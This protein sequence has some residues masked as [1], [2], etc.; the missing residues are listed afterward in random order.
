MCLYVKN[1]L[2]QNIW[3]LQNIEHSFWCT[4]LY[5]YSHYFLGFKRITLHQFFLKLTTSGDLVLKKDLPKQNEPLSKFKDDK[6][7]IFE[8]FNTSL[9]GN[10]GTGFIFERF[11]Y[12]AL[13]L[14]FHCGNI[15][16]KWQA[17]SESTQ[18]FASS[19]FMTSLVPL[20]KWF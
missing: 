12:H 8:D 1:I 19:Y 20:P 6:K 2:K 5:S 11:E 13:F 18:I 15:R 4:T 10:L 9:L 3:V 14:F 16:Q 17:A 7:N